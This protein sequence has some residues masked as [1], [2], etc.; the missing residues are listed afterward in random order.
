[1]ILTPQ[2]LNV[3]GM[4]ENE[5]EEQRFSILHLIAACSVKLNFADMS[6]AAGVRV[7]MECDEECKGNWQGLCCTGR[8]F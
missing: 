6:F 2:C 8:N 4:I 1:M 3:D 7:M 5:E